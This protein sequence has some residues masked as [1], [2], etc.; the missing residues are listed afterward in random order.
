MFKELIYSCLLFIFVVQYL[1]DFFG[2]IL[3]VIAKKNTAAIAT[4]QNVRVTVGLAIFFD[5]LFDLTYH[6]VHFNLAF[7][8][9]RL[10]FLP[11]LLANKLTALL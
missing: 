3:C 10:F 4:P 2:N 8:L 11:Q 9:H 5:F 6:T 7:L 1:Q